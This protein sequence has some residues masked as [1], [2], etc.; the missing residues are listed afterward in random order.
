MT[1]KRLIATTLSLSFPLIFQPTGS[2]AQEPREQLALD[3]LIEE[4][5]TNNPEIKAFAERVRAREAR[6]RVE[7]ALDDPKLKIELEDL[8]KDSLSIGPGN[9]MMT[10]YTISQEFPFPG[11]RPLREK[12]ALKEALSARAELRGREVDVVSMVK[13]AFYDYAYFTEAIKKTVGI[14]DTLSSMSSIAESRYSTGQVTQQDV[15]RANVEAVIVTNELIG[16]EAQKDIAAARLKS[17]LNRPQDQPF[18]EPAGL[19]KE[20]AAFEL[21]ELMDLAAKNSPE[22]RMIEAELEAGELEVDLAGKNSYPDFMVGVAPMQRDGRFDS[23]DLMFQMNIPI[24]RGKYDSL[25]SEARANAGYLRSRLAS[26][27][28]AKGFEVKG[29]AVEVEAAQRMIDLYETTLIPQVELA[30]DSALRNYQAG[31]IEFLSF[32]DAERELKRTRLD[33]LKAILEYRKKITMLERAVGEDLKTAVSV[34]KND[35]K[36]NIR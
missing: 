26:V 30:F 6:A 2:L 31:R 34:S 1:F 23:Y 15:I 16:L 28:N 10:R 21:R 13:D 19:G 4:A 3:A 29:A 12:I 14:R 8:P 35:I 18:G 17:L 9:A 22:V 33:Y 7:G 36:G 24:W 25:S 27:K 20:K 32:L 11:K 5:R